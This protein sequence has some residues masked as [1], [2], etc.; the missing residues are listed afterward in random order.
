MENLTLVILNRSNYIEMNDKQKGDIL[1]AYY[2]AYKEIEE[3]LS[4]FSRADRMAEV[5]K[6]IKTKTKKQN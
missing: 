6:V 4:D 3:K 1:K 5:E 2:K